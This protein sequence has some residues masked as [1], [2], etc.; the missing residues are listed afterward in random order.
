MIRKREGHRV[1][2][3]SESVRQRVILL[4]ALTTILVPYKTLNALQKLV[5]KN[6]LKIYF[7][8][9]SISQ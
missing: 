7:K 4:V 9:V 5:K 1:I 8:H 6:W 3:I 2:I